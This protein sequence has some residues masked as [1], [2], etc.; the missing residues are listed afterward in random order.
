MNNT[1]VDLIQFTFNKKLIKI[2]QFESNRCLKL[3][4]SLGNLLETSKERVGHLII[5]KDKHLV[6]QLR[7]TNHPT[8]F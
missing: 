6:K 5:V 8:Q 3:Y 1:T 4:F 7:E 2:P